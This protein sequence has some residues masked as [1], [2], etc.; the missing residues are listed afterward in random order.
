MTLAP[1]SVGSGW[2]HELAH[3]I[4]SADELLRRLNLPTHS[5]VSHAAAA[6]FPVLV[7]ESFLRR[8][9]PGNPRDPLLLQVLAQT[10]ELESPPGFAADPVGDA[11]ARRSPGL[12][13][14][15][16][17]R[18]LLITTSACAVHC[19]YC[20]RRA[21]PYADEP[22]RPED[23]NPALQLIA[24][25]SSIRE[26]ILSG[27]DPLSL[28]D[29][30]LGEL[31]ERLDAIPHLDRIRI[32]S[33]WPIVIPSRVTSGLLSA[34]Q[35]RR[36]QLIFVVHANHP[37]EIAADCADA[38]RSLVRAGLPV[39]NQAVLLRGINDSPEILESLCL[40]LVNLGVLPYYLHQLDRVAG[41]A[42]FEVPE[43]IG[44][45]LEAEL[46]KRLP[47]YAVPKYV[48]ETAGAESKLPVV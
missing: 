36:C 31:L 21:Y 2:Q 28:S 27:G 32:H 24:H 5:T 26:I 41:A 9:Q 48:R 40:G 22:R 33:R 29:R 43:T 38:L 37:Q 39:L 25:D 46:R 11:A 35:R 16:H 47:G 15:Y 13:H 14:K 3:A 17:G 8:M 7:P 12:L 44:V 4:R 18:A 10:A 20:F 6:D 1:V 23:W 42:H 45:Q 30:R 34:L 19:R